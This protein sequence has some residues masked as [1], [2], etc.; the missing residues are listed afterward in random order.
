MRKKQAPRSLDKV[1]SECL[2]MWR[3]IAS[4]RKSAC[5]LAV[6]VL[7]TQWL[8]K[9]QYGRV[10]YNCFFCNYVRKGSDDTACINC[11]GRQIDGSFDCRRGSYHFF[12]RPAEF[13]AELRRLNWIRLAEKGSQ[14]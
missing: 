8:T 14:K 13:Y 11:P 7:K 5:G 6:D 2:T 1:W 12:N 4:K 9:H 3:W 10:R